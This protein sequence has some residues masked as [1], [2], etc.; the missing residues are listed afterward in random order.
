MNST[1]I[2]PPAR[3]F[4]SHGPP[5]GRSRSRRARMAAASARMRAGGR[6][7]RCAAR[8]AASTRARSARRAGDH[9][10]AGERHALPGP[11]V[12]LGAVVALEGGRA[13]PPPGPLLP[14][15]RSRMSTANIGPTGV[16]RGQR[17]DEGVHRADEP[18][19]GR[20]AGAGAA[21]FRD[22]VR[23]VIDEHQVEVGAG[24]HLPR[25]GLAE[26]HH[27]HGRR[28]AP[29]RSGRRNRPAR[30]AAGRPA[31]RRPAARAPRRRRRRRSVPPWW[32]PRWQKSSARTVARMMRDG[33]LQA[34]RVGQPGAQRCGRRRRDTAGSAALP[35]PAA[36][37][38]DSRRA[39]GAAPSTPATRSSSAG[40][41]W[42]SDSSC[43]PA[44]SRPSKASKRAKAASGWACR[45]SAASRAGSTLCIRSRA[46]CER[47]ARTRPADQPR[48]ASTTGGYRC[49]PW[50][51]APPL[52]PAADRRCR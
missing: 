3:S 16:R 4:T 45:A 42:N 7:W 27:D 21:A 48:T 24:H 52:W 34:A 15:G 18:L 30:A 1:S 46:R 38:P 41:R 44:G 2:C 25:A 8:I 22:V 31:P 13:R 28:R 49:S 37:A 14:D 20:A 32:R 17:G 6:R 40:L 9:A 36:C 12:A 35:A 50:R 10:R 19:A 33:V 47:S 43:T 29:G 11:G 23:M 26:Q 39:T 51:R 5:G